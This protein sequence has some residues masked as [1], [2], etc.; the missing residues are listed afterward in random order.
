[1]I[2]QKDRNEIG[3]ITV[4]DILFKVLQYI[5]TSL[6]EKHLEAYVTMVC[7]IVLTMEKKFQTA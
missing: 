1:M 3:S 5:C 7:E 6:L 2:P 4:G